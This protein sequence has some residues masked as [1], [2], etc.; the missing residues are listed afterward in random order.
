MLIWRVVPLFIMWM[1]WQ[2][3]NRRDFNDASLNLLK[4]MFIRSLY[5]WMNIALGSHSFH[6]FLDFISLL[7]LRINFLED[8]VYTS[9]VLLST[10][11]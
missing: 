5:D 6:S 9:R 2:D 4:S 11:Y 8:I 3:R 1:L 10:F 7:N